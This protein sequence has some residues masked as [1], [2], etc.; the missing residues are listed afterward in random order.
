VNPLNAIN[1]Y[2][3]YIGAVG[4]IAYGV[5][6]ITQ[7]QYD[8]AFASISAGVAALG[9]AHKGDKAIAAASK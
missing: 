4:L 3:S 9:L 2:K 7:K 1:G 8:A 5:Y 6:Q